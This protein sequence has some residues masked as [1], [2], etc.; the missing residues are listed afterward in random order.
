[1]I[2][3]VPCIASDVG[4]TTTMLKHESEGYIYQSNAPYMLAYYVDRIFS[5]GE[6]A[7]VMCDNARFHAL[8][9]HSKNTILS[10]TIELY[11]SVLNC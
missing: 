3:G 4:G 1:M 10:K 8:N 7:D 6:K 5:L 11:E 2:L 9:T